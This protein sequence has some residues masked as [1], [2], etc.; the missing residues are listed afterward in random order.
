LLPHR[1]S[2][3][4]QLQPAYLLLPSVFICKDEDSATSTGIYPVD[5][6]LARK[7]NI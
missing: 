2:L 7:R 6:D 5:L 1:N 4:V 3:V